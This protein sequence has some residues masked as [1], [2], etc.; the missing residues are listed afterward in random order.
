LFGDPV[1]GGMNSPIGRVQST[2]NFLGEIL[3]DEEANISGI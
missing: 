2:R 3:V 1:S